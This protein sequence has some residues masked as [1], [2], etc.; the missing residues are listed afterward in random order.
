MRLADFKMDLY[1][2]RNE[3]ERLY[4]DGPEETDTRRSFPLTAVDV[5]WL[6]CHFRR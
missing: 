4:V 2:N 6:F 1:S 3:E 5:T